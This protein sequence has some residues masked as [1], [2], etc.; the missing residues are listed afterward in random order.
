VNFAD[1]LQSFDWAIRPPAGVIVEGQVY[2]RLQERP[3]LYRPDIILAEC[4]AEIPYFSAAVGPIPTNGLDMRVN[5]LAG[6]T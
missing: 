3:G 6:A 2:W 5:Q 4:A 1:R